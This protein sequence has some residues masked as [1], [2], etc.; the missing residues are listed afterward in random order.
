MLLKSKLVRQDVDDLGWT[1][2]RHVGI[3][4]NG[5]NEGFKFLSLI[6]LFH[7]VYQFGCDRVRRE[8]EGIFEIVK[9]LKWN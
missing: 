6:E 8:L 2:S 5:P 3:V 9:L 7:R 1:V 4:Q